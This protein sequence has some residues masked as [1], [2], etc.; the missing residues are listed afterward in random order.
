LCLK[1][2][3]AVI[4]SQWSATNISK[5]EQLK[6]EPDIGAE[7]T[8]VAFDG[9]TGPDLQEIPEFSETESSHE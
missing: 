4:F 2:Q 3:P 9:G 8:S 1:I 6:P 5:N 7:E